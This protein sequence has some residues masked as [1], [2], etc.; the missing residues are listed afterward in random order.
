MRRQLAALLCLAALAGPAAA[1][2]LTLEEALAAASEPHPDLDLALAQYELS[3][4]QQ[5][6]S[7]S[8]YDFRVTLEASLRGGINPVYNDEFKSDSYAR[9]NVRKTLLDGGELAAGLDAARLETEARSLELMDV[10]AQRRLTVMARFFDVLLNDLQYAADTELMAVAYV[11]WDDAKVRHEV[12]ELSTSALAALEASYQEIRLRRND[13]ERRARERRAQLASAM[14]R[15]GQLPAELAEPVF[16]GNDRP[17]PEFEVLLDAMRASNPRLKV[18]SQLLEASRSRL[19]GLRLEDSPR[20]EVEAEAATY[21]RPSTT[22][23]ELRGALN[24]V[25]PLFTGRRTDGLLAQEMARFQG[26]QA[27]YDKA[28]LDLRQSLYETWHEIQF[29]RDV[30][31]RAAEVNAQYRD[32]ALERARAEY[33]MELR[34]NL[35]NSMA[36]T[37]VAKMR[38]QSV[39]YRLTLAW[40]RMAALLGRPVE[41]IAMEGKR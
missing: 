39:E 15:P 27:Q 4:A 5:M 14:N 28:V 3:R 31:R 17:L 29:L 23:D 40:E 26:L 13:T 19:A 6:L 8:L 41:E 22:R 25:W 1:K 33:E 38:R 12:G 16:K 30:E 10:R 7:E 36:E 2:P 20:L 21:T 32:L 18:Y 34:T 37:Q 24:L 11:R 9:L 35:G